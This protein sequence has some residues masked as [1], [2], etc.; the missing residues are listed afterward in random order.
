MCCAPE[1]RSLRWN[2]LSVSPVF[3][4]FL[5]HSRLVVFVGAED[6][7]YALVID[8]KAIGVHAICHS[9]D[10]YRRPCIYCQ[11]SDPSQEPCEDVAFASEDDFS[12]EDSTAFL[13]EVLFS[14]E[15][16]ETRTLFTSVL[17]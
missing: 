5:P 3:F 16:E 2:A 17:K 4:F 6:D 9:T 15:S 11:L 8:C 1:R 10:I 14:P 12:V 13:S 7:D